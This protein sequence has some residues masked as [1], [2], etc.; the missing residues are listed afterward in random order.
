VIT[1]DE[2]AQI[3]E[4]GRALYAYDQAAWYATDAVR[5]TNPRNEEVGRYIARKTEKG[6]EVAFGRLNEA[7]DAF[8][9][10]YIATQGKTLQEFSVEHLA[11]PQSDTGFYLSAAKAID[12]ALR[13]FQGEKRPY[14]I[15]ILPATDGKLCV[16]VYP[17]QTEN[18][19]YPHGGDERYHISAD[20]S[21]IIEKRRLHNDIL[22]FDARATNGLTPQSG[23]HTH[24]LSE[25]PEDTDVFYVLSRRPSIPEYI[26][27]RGKRFYVVKEDGTV[28]FAK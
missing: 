16:Y 14:N 26:G 5:A 28:L 15:A 23:W 13:D 6:W 4:R 22:V 19:V 12:L 9:V 3:T 10:A 7:H 18:G 1:A 24:V 2:L 21:S 8:L 25:V 11:T 20:G 17:A 27:T